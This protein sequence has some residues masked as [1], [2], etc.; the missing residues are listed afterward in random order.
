MSTTKVS[1]TLTE[2]LV[3]EAKTR[4]RARVPPLPHAALA[5]RSSSTGW[6]TLSAISSTSS[7]RS[8]P[9]RAG[10]WTRWSGQ[11]DRQIEGASP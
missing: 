9:R 3:V 10:R 5:G 1:T 11:A 4:V 6:Q 8:P 7:A 2:E